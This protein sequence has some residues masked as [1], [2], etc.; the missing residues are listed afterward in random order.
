MK[1]RNQPRAA[2]IND[3]ELLLDPRPDMAI[4]A[5]ALGIIV[6]DFLVALPGLQ[7]TVAALVAEPGQTLSSLFTVEPEP[8]P[9]RVVVKKKG[10][11][12]EGQLMERASA[13][14]R[15]ARRCSTKPFRP[16][17][18]DLPDSVVLK[19]PAQIMPTTGIL[20]GGIVAFSM[21]RGIQIGQ[22]PHATENNTAAR[23]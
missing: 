22:Q 16:T 5:V 12:V 17:R 7:M 1:Q 13:L 4:V 20:S 3:A 14:A 15:R 8:S 21:S 10:R 2:L 18:S 6:Q 11:S 19:N 9:N 23:T